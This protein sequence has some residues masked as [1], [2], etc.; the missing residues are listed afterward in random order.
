M[1]INHERT[2]AV[3]VHRGVPERQ[4][5]VR[6]TTAAVTPGRSLRRTVTPAHT[7]RD[8]VRNLRMAVSDLQLKVS[9][10]SGAFGHR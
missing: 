3:A 10:L 7:L 2:G 8:Q 4:V 1:Q 9:D 6:H 5:T